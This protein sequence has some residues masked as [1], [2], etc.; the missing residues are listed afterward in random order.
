MYLQ[1]K[2]V[3]VKDANF[4]LQKFTAIMLR[5]YSCFRNL[6]IQEGMVPNYGETDIFNNFK[7]LFIPV[8]LRPNAGND[9]I[10]LE[11][12]RSHTTTYQSR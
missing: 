1:R 5:T 8:E 10:F 3:K 12:S 11:V 2:L 4:P 9:I 7:D 6:L